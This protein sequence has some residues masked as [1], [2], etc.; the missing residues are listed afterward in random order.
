MGADREEGAVAGVAIEP[1]LNEVRRRGFAGFEGAPR[2]L[3]DAP[4]TRIGGDARP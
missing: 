2:E 1:A 4:R 3:N